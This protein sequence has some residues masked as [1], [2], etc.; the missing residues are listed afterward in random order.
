MHASK[1]CNI[2]SKY[3]AF[4]P[5]D[6]NKSRYL[7]TVVGYPN[8]G[9]AEAGSSQWAR[10][11]GWAAEEPRPVGRGA[12][13]GLEAKKPQGEGLTARGWG[14]HKPPAY[15]PAEGCTTIPLPFFLLNEFDFIVSFPFGMYH[16][17]KC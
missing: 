16:C 8:A 3:T 2:I 7:P 10:G 17:R 15:C 4:V 9:K 11:G 5:V 1:A 13:K 6:I 12:G 14:A